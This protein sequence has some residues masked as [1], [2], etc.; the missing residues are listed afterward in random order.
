MHWRK[1]QGRW[2]NGIRDP[3]HSWIF[4][5][6]QF[7]LQLIK[8]ILSHVDS[9]YKKVCSQRFRLNSTVPVV[10]SFSQHLKIIPNKIFS[11]Y[12]LLMKKSHSNFLI[13]R[14]KNIL[15][16]PNFKIFSMMSFMHHKWVKYILCHMYLFWIRFWRLF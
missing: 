14:R 9:I 10:K 16:W 8:T 3:L 1:R 2:S 15:N 5:I 7:Q 4:S 11:D 13:A 6:G 12:Y